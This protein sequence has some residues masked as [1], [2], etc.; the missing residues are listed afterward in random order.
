MRKKVLITLDMLEAAYQSNRVTLLP[1]VASTTLETR[2]YMAILPPITWNAF[3][4]KGKPS[5]PPLE[6]L[7]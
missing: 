4:E 3:Y 7:K 5:H 6:A 2:T 1:Y